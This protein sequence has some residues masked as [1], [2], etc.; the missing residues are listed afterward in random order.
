MKPLKD[1]VIGRQRRWS[2][3]I[4]KVGGLL[5]S[6]AILSV[7]CAESDS[8]DISSEFQTARVE[9]LTL[10]SS[11][12]ATGTVEPVKLIDVKSQASGVI[13]G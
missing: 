9:R 1:H 3:T 10:V 4:L 7:A 13:S 2:R 12:E 8:A 6:A 11:V 5:V